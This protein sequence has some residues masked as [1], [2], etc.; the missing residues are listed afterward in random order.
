MRS[1]GEKVDGYLLLIGGAEDKKGKQLI[2]KRFVELIQKKSSYIVIFTIATRDAQSVGSEY[3]KI[4]RKLGE[5]GIKILQINNRTQAAAKENGDILKDAGGI[6]FTGGDQL[7]ITS[8]LGG[9]AVNS[10]LQDAY[11]SG[12]IIAGTSAGASAV[13]DT[14]I[15]A[16][17]ND[18][19]PRMKS[20]ELAPGLGL[21]E[22]VVIDQHFAQR[23]RLGRLLMTVAYNPHILGIGIDEDTALEINNQAEVIVRGSRTVT[24]IDGRDISHSNVSEIGER[25]PLA[26]LDVKVHILP[27]G[28]TFNLQTRV[29]GL[30]E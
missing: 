21:L 19:T 17:D 29:A 2:L 16:G 23:G 28:Y 4:F 27:P 3:Q 15:V 20:V 18:Q 12:A 5:E 14:M 11:H 8:L 25:E 9:T 10:A 30:P 22:E 6:F 7:R 24:I 13:S 26:L 1:L